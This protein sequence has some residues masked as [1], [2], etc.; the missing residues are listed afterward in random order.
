MGRVLSPIFVKQ[1]AD[2]TW[3]Y[4]LI[5][6]FSGVIK[7]VWGVQASDADIAE[8]NAAVDAE[9]QP[10]GRLEGYTPYRLSGPGDP[11]RDRRVQ[12]GTSPPGGTEAPYTVP[13]HG[14]GARG[15][16]DGDAPL[17]PGGVRPRVVFGERERTLSEVRDAI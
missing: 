8:V 7:Q 6:S 1:E 13:L 14:R 11:P 16:V 5:G 10:G 4:R 2:G 12:Q 15:I 9:L 17:R 3:S